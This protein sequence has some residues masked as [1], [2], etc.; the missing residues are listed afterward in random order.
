MTESYSLRFPAEKYREESVEYRGKTLVRRAYRHLPY[1]AKPVSVDYQSLDVFVPVS[2]GEKVFDTTE[3]PIILLNRCGGY[4]AHRNR[5][6]VPHMSPRPKP[7]PAPCDPRMGPAPGREGGGALSPE[8]SVLAA[9]AAGFVVVVPG[10][11]GVGCVT[12]GGIYYGKAPAMI[13]DLKAAVRYLRRN[14]DIIPG[15]TDHIILREFLLPS[16][17]KWLHEQTEETR[18]I[19]LEDRPWL[20]WNGEQASFRFADYEIYLGRL[21][22]LTPFD[23]FELGRGENTVFGSEHEEAQHYTVF[24]LRHATGDAD[25]YLPTTVVTQRNLLNPMV[26]LRKGSG[27]IAQHW[28][29]RMGAKESG[30]ACP[31]VVNVVTALEKHEKA[32]GF[33]PGMGRRTLRRG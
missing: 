5:G 29:I 26:R 21:K 13:V 18:R 9:L 15:N 19:Y 23:S 27:K 22:P 28:W 20:L 33:S 30:F 10:N 17:T 11:R 7:A 31:L 6:D 32:G 25:A 14:A 8:E 24:S 3:A 16:A 1:A 4:R 12:P 2:Y